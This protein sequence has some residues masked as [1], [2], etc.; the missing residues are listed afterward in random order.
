MARRLTDELDSLFGF[1]SEWSFDR[2]A[3]CW[4]TNGR[5]NI[6]PD[7]VDA[8]TAGAGI[9]QEARD[10]VMRFVCG[11]EKAHH[12]QE[13][14]WPLRNYKIEHHVME[15]EADLVGAWALAQRKQAVPGELMEIVRRF[16][17]AYH[18]AQRLGV[19]IGD[20]DESKPHHPWAEQRHLALARGPSLAIA[21]PGP[22]ASDARGL[23]AQGIKAIAHDLRGGRF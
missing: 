12:L 6:D 19:E 23:F 10:I 8:V 21:H 5:V 2:G 3:T 22:L 14:V 11:H 13:L 16:D 18:I 1:T 20:K 4:E 15:I 9:G 17:D 7:E